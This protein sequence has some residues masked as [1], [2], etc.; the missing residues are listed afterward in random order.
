[1]SDTLPL[2]PLLVHTHTHTAGCRPSSGSSHPVGGPAVDALPLPP[3]L[4]LQLLELIAKSKLPS[5]SGVAQ[6]NYMNILEGVVQ[7]GKPRPLLVVC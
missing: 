3:L 5:L 1:M 2:T 4:L 7:R 6:K